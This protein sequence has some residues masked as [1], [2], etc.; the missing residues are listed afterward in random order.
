[1]ARAFV[2]PDPRDRSYNQPSVIVDQPKVLGLY[3]QEYK[4]RP[5]LQI[6]TE[7]IRQW[8]LEEAKNRGWDEATFAG[9]QCTLRVDFATHVWQP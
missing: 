4:P 8:F 6:V 7:D 2:F 9:N 1:M 5:K 3:N